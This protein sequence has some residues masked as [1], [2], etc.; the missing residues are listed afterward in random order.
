MTHLKF[1]F[2]KDMNILIFIKNVKEIIMKILI[3]LSKK[4]YHI[5][6]I[7]NFLHLI[8]INKI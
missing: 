4:L 2:F 5:I 8:K 3:V 1:L 7:F 6:K